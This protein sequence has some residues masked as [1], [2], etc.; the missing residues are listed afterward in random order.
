MFELL[1]K[2]GPLMIP[3]LLCSLISLTVILERT[4]YWLLVD[5]KRNQNLAETILD[6]F[7]QEK[8]NEIK[9]ISQQSKNKIVR[10]LS[11]GIMHRNYSL[12]KALEA[13]ALAETKDMRHYMGVLETMITIA[14]LLGILGTVTGIINSFELLGTA[15]VEAP[16]VV[17]A[18]I[19]QA[20]LTTA[21][22]LAIAIF[23]VLPFNYF[24]TKIENAYQLIESYATRLEIIQEKKNNDQ[25]QQQT[26]S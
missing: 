18:G 19:A 14:P 12:S 15:Q 26:Q 1:E 4:I 20:L 17:T 11:S 3:L 25:G 16:Q 6:L 23:A 10:I 8:L 7:A 24:N 9:N 13:A 5:I 21:T 22:G 2:G